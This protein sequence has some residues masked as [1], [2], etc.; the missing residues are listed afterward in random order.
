[1]SRFL[2]LL[3]FLPINASAIGKYV[4]GGYAFGTGS[5]MK[6]LT[7]GQDYGINAGAGYHIAGGLILVISDTKPHAFELQGG[8][9]YMFTSAGGADNLVTFRRW[10]SELI[11]YYRNTDNNFRLGWG[12]IYHFETE[13]DA[14]GINAGAGGKVDPSL[15]WAVSAQYLLPRGAIGARYNHIT[16]KSPRFSSDANGGGVLLTVEFHWP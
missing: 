2:Y 1:M 8:V 7:G 14:K 15:G 4:S 11:Y 9:G 12:G 3:L 6:K 16:Y 5:E 10:T 13:I